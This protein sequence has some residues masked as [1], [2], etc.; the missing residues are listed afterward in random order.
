MTKPKLLQE[1]TAPPDPAIAEEIRRLTKE[2]SHAKDDIAAAQDALDLTKQSL[3]EAT[4]NQG[5]ELEE[6]AKGR[7]E[8]VTRLKAEHGE[9]LSIPCCSKVRNWR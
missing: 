6:A 5:K 3:E 1:T 9:E 8:E 2:L 7:A 4:N